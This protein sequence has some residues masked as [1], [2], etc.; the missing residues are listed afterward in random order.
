MTANL[1]DFAPFAHLVQVV[2]PPNPRS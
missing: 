1:D 2:A